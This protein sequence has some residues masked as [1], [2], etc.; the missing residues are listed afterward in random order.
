MQ[1]NEPPPKKLSFRVRSA[2]DLGAAVKYFRTLHGLS[3]AAL[4]ERA[5]IHRSYLAALE[6]GH[7]TEALERLM[8]LFGELEVQLSVTK[9]G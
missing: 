7:A 3:Q 9:E 8:T 1:T 2:R 4:A 6:N 5:G